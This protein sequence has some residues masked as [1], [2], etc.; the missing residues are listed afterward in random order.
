MCIAHTLVAYVLLFDV[1][2][3]VNDILYC[4]PG[5]CILYRYSIVHLY[6]SKQVYSTAGSGWVRGCVC[7][8]IIVINRRYSFTNDVDSIAYKNETLFLNLL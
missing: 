1:Q 2:F 4:L 8:H 7:V 6:G 3:V 5:G